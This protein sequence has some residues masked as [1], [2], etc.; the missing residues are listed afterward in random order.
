MFANLICIFSNTKTIIRSDQRETLNPEFNL[1]LN[2]MVSWLLDL[3]IS[4]RASVLRITFEIND[5]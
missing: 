5:V 1:Q 3:F 2:Y 4:V